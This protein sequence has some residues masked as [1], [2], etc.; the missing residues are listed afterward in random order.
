M[1]PAS[2]LA[3]KL[4]VECETASDSVVVGKDAPKEY[5]DSDPSRGEPGRATSGCVF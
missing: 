2:A 3:K 1:D 5:W 4:A